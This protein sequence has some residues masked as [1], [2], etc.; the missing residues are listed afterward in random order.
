MLVSQETLSAYSAV[1]AAVVTATVVEAL[2]LKVVAGV[3]E[4]A[5]VS[6]A[7]KDSSVQQLPERIALTSGEVAAAAVVDA[8][9]ADQNAGVPF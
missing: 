6:V 7:A 9:I 2:P 1:E 5:K 3:V 4:F 8:K